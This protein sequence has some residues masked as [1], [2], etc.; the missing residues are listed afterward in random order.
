MVGTVVTC[1]KDDIFFVLEPNIQLKVLLTI[2]VP[3]IL[4]VRNFFFFRGK[5]Y[6]QAFRE[7]FRGV[8]KVKA[9]LEKSREKCYHIFGTRHKNNP[10]HFHN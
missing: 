3:L 9:P 10:L 5:T 2:N 4:K 8:K 7:I 1:I 6:N